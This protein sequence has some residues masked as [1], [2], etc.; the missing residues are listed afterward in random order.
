MAHYHAS[1]VSPIAI[2][3]A[4]TYLAD[5]TNAADWDPGVSAARRLDDGPI[6]VGSRFE[7]KARF[8]GRDLPLRYRITQLDPATRVVFEAD[9]GGL[10]AV[11]SI[12]FEKTASGTRVIWDATLSLK[13]LRYVADLPLHLAFQWIGRQ[14]LE[15]LQAAL[16][17]RAAAQ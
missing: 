9:G 14:A 11:D 7:L 10:R 16:D 17:A 13:G 2:D 5:F 15:G 6:A 1:F 3:D 4:F 8:L 12:S